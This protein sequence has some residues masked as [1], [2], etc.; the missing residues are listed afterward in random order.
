[1]L[2][3]YDYYVYRYIIS[4]FILDNKKIYNLEKYKQKNSDYINDD[5]IKE[6]YD[7]K[8]KKCNIFFYNIIL[9]L[10]KLIPKDVIDT[11]DEFDLFLNGVE[12]KYFLI[13]DIKDDQIIPNSL[14]SSKNSSLE[15]INN[16]YNILQKN[17]DSISQETLIGNESLFISPSTSIEKIFSN[18][19]SNDE[20]DLIEKEENLKVKATTEYYNICP[21]NIYVNESHER[22]KNCIKIMM[23]WNEITEDKNDN[24][25]DKFMLLSSE[26]KTNFC[27]ELIHCLENFFRYDY[28]H[29]ILL[30]G[31]ISCLFYLINDEFH[32]KL[33]K[34]DDHTSSIF[35]QVLKKLSD[36]A[37]KVSLTIENFSKKL[38]YIKQEMF[39]DHFYECILNKSF[40]N[41][42]FK[43]YTK[44]LNISYE[45]NQF[46]FSYILLQEFIKEI[47]SIEMAFIMFDSKHESKEE[48]NKVKSLKLRNINDNIKSK[49]EENQMNCSD[50]IN[51]IDKALEDKIDYHKEEKEI[52]EIQKEI[53][54]LQ[55]NEIF[56][57]E[58]EKEKS[59]EDG[60]MKSIEEIND[61]IINSIQ[62]NFSEKYILESEDLLKENFS[63]INKSQD[64][65]TTITGTTSNINYS[66][67]LFGNISND[68]S[69]S[70]TTEL[71]ITQEIKKLN[72]L[73]NNN[74]NINMSD[75]VNPFEYE[76]LLMENSVT[77]NNSDIYE[78]NLKK[79]SSGSF[80]CDINNT[81]N[82][83]MFGSNSDDRKNSI[84]K[85]DFPTTVFNLENE[86][87]EE[88]FNRIIHT[89][90]EKDER[91]FNISKFSSKKQN[92][93][94][95]QIPLVSETNTE[96]SRYLNELPASPVLP[97]T[98]LKANN[99]EHSSSSNSLLDPIE[100]EE[101][102]VYL[103]YLE[104]L[105][106]N[107][108][109]KKNSENLEEK[110]I[111]IKEENDDDESK[112]ED[113]EEIENEL[114]KENE[115][116]ISC[117][118]SPTEGTVNILIMNDI[119]ETESTEKDNSS[120][121]KSKKSLKNFLSNQKQKINSI[122][123]HKNNIVEPETSEINSSTLSDKKDE[124]KENSEISYNEFY[125]ETFDE[126]YF[127]K[128]NLNNGFG[129]L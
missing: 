42:S 6:F 36:Y 102:L 8:V 40:Y 65:A 48:K 56:I 97:A 116:I 30:T 3:G 121:K 105:T 39:F 19:T 52:K 126:S 21:T 51:I 70:K 68:T 80:W 57:K 104:N 129:Y 106:Q 34:N 50:I 32:I 77:A 89:K 41:C 23:S 44:L 15:N 84:K 55:L 25:V 16:N 26:I 108:K 95:L 5:K 101:D 90:N 66:L 2:S 61:T 58:L 46:L 10:I 114:E 94:E 125:S 74:D 100:D 115:K 31:C 124:F 38:K 85:T 111:E 35:F 99:G 33:F 119:E 9:H 128:K 75:V 72:A 88:D 13:H 53:E 20:F 59:K 27:K 103:E 78:I 45:E 12:N 29:N 93:K 47:I 24:E 1:M 87:E 122:F 67:D 117:N 83:F 37:N 110:D 71:N 14:I 86:I 92:E 17:E 49:D 81:D 69:I 4:N 28:E 96:Y 109:S 113:E 62:Q 120:S 76:S 7:E 112:Y 98:L 54:K 64:T 22:I 123:N 82:S 127:L 91:E 73:F 11:K 63:F 79:N 60:V 118:S 18:H 43:D 107:N